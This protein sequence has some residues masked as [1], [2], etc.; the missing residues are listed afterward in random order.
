MV[1][2]HGFFG[3]MNVSRR[4]HQNVRVPAKSKDGQTIFV[5]IL[6]DPLPSAVRTFAMLPQSS[7]AS[8]E[9]SRT[10]RCCHSPSHHHSQ[11]TSHPLRR[12]QSNVLLLI[13]MFQLCISVLLWICF[14]CQSAYTLTQHASSRPHRLRRLQGSVLSI[15]SMDLLSFIFYVRAVFSPCFL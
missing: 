7:R 4:P 2:R 14:C 15:L 13:G 6:T 12:L 11:T 8:C 3:R 1:L 5:S 10:F 9:H